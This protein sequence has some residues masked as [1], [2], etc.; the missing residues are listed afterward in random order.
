M[1]K[2]QKN[3]YLEL[4]RY[5]KNNKNY[6]LASSKE[7]MYSKDHKKYCK[8]EI[9]M[10]I[11]KFRKCNTIKSEEVRAVNKVVNR[12][13]LSDFFANKNKNFLGGKYVQK[14]EKDC[15]KYFKV[16]HAITVNSWTSGLVAIIGSLNV[17]P[18]D[19]I[20]LSP[21]DY[22]CLLFGNYSLGLYPCF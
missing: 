12:G 21:L 9:H 7:I 20:I 11:I 2:Y 19:E 22:V 16:K 1:K 10:G 3:F 8:T 4:L 6:N 15:K 18:G 17:K 13:I 5:I 14:F